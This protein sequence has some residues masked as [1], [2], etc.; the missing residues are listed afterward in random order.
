MAEGA[1]AVRDHWGF[2]VKRELQDLYQRIA[3]V[4]ADEEAERSQR[5]EQYLGELQAA[6]PDSEQATAESEPQ[7]LLRALSHLTACTAAGEPPAQAAPL[8]Q[9]LSSLVQAG[10]P[11]SKR[12]A[13]W[14]LFLNVD[15]SQRQGEY[16]QLVAEVQA[17][18]TASLASTAAAAAATGAAAK[19]QPAATTQHVFEVSVDASSTAVLVELEVKY[20]RQYQQYHAQHSVDVFSV[21]A[22]EECEES[23]QCTPAKAAPGI[24]G[25]DPS[26]GGSCAQPCS[27]HGKPPAAAQPSAKLLSEQ[28][29]QQQQQQQQEAAE[30]SPPLATPASILQTPEAC[31][32]ASSCGRAGSPN[33]CGSG[34]G[35]DAADSAARQLDYLAQIDKDLHRTFPNHPVMDAGGRAALRRILCAYSRRNATVGYCQG[36]NFLAATFL[37]LLPEEQ[38]FWCLAAMVERVLGSSY[39]DE[40]M[41]APQVDVLVFGHLL[42]G[43]FPTLWRHLQELEVDA[44]SVT[45]HWFLLGFL[46]SLPLDSVLRVWDLLFFEG[47]PVVL[48]RVA[49]SLALMCTRESSDAYMLLQCCAQ[50]TFDGSRLVD[51]ACIGFSHLRRSGLEALRQRYRPAV[52]DNLRSSFASDEEYDRYLGSQQ[53]SPGS[54]CSSASSGSGGNSSSGD[55]G[56]SSSSADGQQPASFA[57]TFQ[58][59]SSAV[60][61]AEEEALRAAAAAAAAADNGHLSG[62]PGG[63]R[64]GGVNGSGSLPASPL[65]RVRQAVSG[66]S[67]RLMPSA[68]PPLLAAGAVDV[69]GQEQQPLCSTPPSARSSPAASSNSLAANADKPSSPAAAVQAPVGLHVRRISTAARPGTSPAASPCGSAGSGAV[70]SRH[71]GALPHITPFSALEE[72]ERKQ[73][74]VFAAQHSRKGLVA[75]TPPQ[76]RLAAAASPGSGGRTAP[77]PPSAAAAAAAAAFQS[78]PATPCELL[79]QLAPPVAAHRRALTGDPGSHASGSRRRRR[80]L[81]L[82]LLNLAEL[83]PDLG[84]PGVAA[85][86]AI[87]APSPRPVGPPV[88]QPGPTSASG[89]RRLS[90]PAAGLLA[91]GSTAGRT[92]AA[93]LQGGCQSGTRSGGDGSCEDATS[94]SLIRALHFGEGGESD[95]EEDVGSQQGLWRTATA[96]TAALLS[97]QAAAATS[98]AAARL[99]RHSEPEAS[100]TSN[101]TYDLSLGLLSHSLPS[102]R[103]PSPGGGRRQVPSLS[104]VVGQLQEG[105]AVAESRRH[106]AEVAAQHAQQM[107]ADLQRQLDKVLGQVAAKESLVAELEERLQASTEK[108]GVLAAQR[109]AA[110]AETAQAEQRRRQLAAADALI[111]RLVAA[112]SAATAAAKRSGGSGATSSGSP[113]TNSTSSKGSGADSYPYH[114]ASSTSP[115]SSSGSAAGCR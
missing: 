70:L 26:D 35:G 14:L 78:M 38:A 20:Q 90:T 76:H 37:L 55:S 59:L 94:G 115:Q 33:T 17:I 21:T 1:A 87:A 31:S 13:F 57:A 43:R 10:L 68:L 39:F 99:L 46:N 107:A 83:R 19:Q 86:L 85:A 30:D 89:G 22:L 56:S 5:W 67:S 27:P 49:L 88:Q 42:Q 47:S 74:G 109:M 23:P 24:G 36:L 28:Q 45:M 97:A 106:N 54:A 75:C 2:L 93:V 50:M 100:S 98:R 62:R 48:F 79:V 18:E 72:A 108:G 103:Q 73:G 32:T 3:P 6:V 64:H 91:E 53:T 11:M 111:Q 41:A 80:R 61:A 112:V 95:N 15:T 25:C 69:R 52:M 114:S 60:L 40:R 65:A 51:T 9:R 92:A 110:E 58:L 29:Q 8:L 82:D 12:G 34:G 104:A 77:W 105:V 7:L 16:Q 96:P 84:Q 66:L 63:R 113:A 102:S 4:L 101:G 81:T 71:G 44:A